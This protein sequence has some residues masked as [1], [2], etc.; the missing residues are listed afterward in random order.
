MEAQNFHEKDFFDGRLNSLKRLS[1]KDRTRLREIVKEE[2]VVTNVVQGRR[3]C[4]VN[5]QIHTQLIDDGGSVASDVA[6]GC[7]EADSSEAQA[8]VDSR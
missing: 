6:G 7:I 3:H 1:E 4:D 5:S 8:Q 2:G